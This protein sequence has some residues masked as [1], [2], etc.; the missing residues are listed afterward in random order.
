MQ[1]VQLAPRESRAESRHDS[2]PDAT[3]R[4]ANKRRGAPFRRAVLGTSL[5]LFALASS[6]TFSAAF[7][8]GEPANPDATPSD[9]PEADLNIQ[10]R[11]AGQ[12]TGV[13]GRSTLLGDMGGIRPW[14]GQYGVTLQATEVSE[15]LYNTR[16][17]LQTGGTYDGLTTVTLGL[18]TQKAF[19][20]QGGTF[21]VSAL[22]I[23]GRNLSE[24]NLGTLNTASGIKAQ[25]TKACGNSGISSRS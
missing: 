25:D 24:F 10:A 1:P 11:P 9:T 13:W 18:D 6:A 21:N 19:G 22:Q 20:L 16:G 8:A 4:A 2:R 23:H 7:A 3:L 15:Y 12:W 17:G 5:A 14:L